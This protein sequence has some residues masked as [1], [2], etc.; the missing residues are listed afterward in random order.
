MIQLKFLIIE[1]S[2]W[3][4]SCAAWLQERGYAVD[5]ESNWR[6]GYSRS[7]QKVYDL[8]IIDEVFLF[9]DKFKLSL[10]KTDLAIVSSQYTKE[11]YK[12]VVQAGGKG[13]INKDLNQDT[14]IREL[15]KT[16]RTLGKLPKHGRLLIVD[17]D[18]N[19]LSAL[20]NN[21]SR[22]GYDVYITEKAE[23]ARSIVE[24]IQPHVVMIDI[25]LRDDDDTLD[26]SGFDLIT[27]F[28]NKYGHA[29][30]LIGVTGT[31][32]RSA[33]SIATGLISGFLLKDHS[34]RN[35]DNN[36]L[37]TK[38]ETA[39]EELGINLSLEIEFKEPL[40]LPG[41]VE[42]I[43][44]Y[45]DVS[46]KER[47][48]VSIEIKELI[49]KLFRRELKVRGT[50]LHPGR[51][52][53][54]VVL[55]RPIVEGTKGQHFVIKF[56]PRE[57]MNTELDNYNL[58]VKPFVGKH[59]TQ[60][61]DIADKPIETLNLGG[62]KF[63]FAG[64]SV[65]E[66]RDFN[67]FYR[68][69]NITAER[70]C[71]SLDHLFR[72]T[73]GSWYQAKRDWGN[74]DPNGLALAYEA[75]LSLSHP[76]KLKEVTDTFMELSNGKSF[77]NIIFRINNQDRIDVQLGELNILFPS[78]MYYLKNNR[79]TFPEPQFECRTHGDLNSRNMFID[80]DNRV[81]LIDFFKTG[82]GPILRDFT[83]LECAIKFELLDTNNFRALYEFE[84]ALLTPDRFDR[85]IEFANNFH[86]DDFNRALIAIIKL[87]KL[88]HDVFESFDM[89]EYYIGLLYYAIKMITWEGV[90]SAEVDRYPIRQRHAL[91]SAA[92]IS[93]RLT[94]WSNMWDGWPDD[95]TIVHKV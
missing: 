28:R 61:I 8:I 90:S 87:R 89:K 14:F 73:C 67:A 65:D 3:A 66:P 41:L 77:H 93:H 12:K 91:L 60:L 38:I 58:F 53:S 45:R 30:K 81:W 88:A 25:R 64:M 44:A 4:L 42:M 70:V 84:K 26:Q 37:I 50:Y 17:N 57:T 52:G 56:G 55:M 68:D 49:Q 35:I 13:Y 78:P 43:K 33:I 74:K 2:N 29:I 34:T 62:L 18:K 16:L 82:W 39:Y 85:S 5:V 20:K 21:L 22:E 15:E 36:E 54:G 27:E 6:S 94:G 10:I 23:D 92:M 31:P 19:V 63:S 83:E 46:D 86:I 80:E 40:S 1:S 69:P 59:S 95:N 76:D 71:L 72:E 11:G 75:Q 47:E 24:I 32:G 9:D 7:K 48:R 79:G 51:G